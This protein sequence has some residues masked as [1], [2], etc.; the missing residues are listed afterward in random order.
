MFLNAT[1]QQTTPP[2]Q[3][4]MLLD[5]LGH[6]DATFIRALGIQVD[7]VKLYIAADAGHVAPTVMVN[8][9]AVNMTDTTRGGAEVA[10]YNASECVVAMGRSEDAHIVTVTVCAVVTR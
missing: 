1:I 6:T 7:P 8:D 9:M 3:V 10:V 2:V 5:D 4:N